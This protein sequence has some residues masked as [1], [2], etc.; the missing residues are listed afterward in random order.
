M[1]TEYILNG[2]QADHNMAD[3]DICVLFPTIDASEIRQFRLSK[4]MTQEQ[5]ANFYGI[6][7]RTLRRWE[8]THDGAP[9][10]YTVAFRK[11]LG[12][13]MGSKPN[14]QIETSI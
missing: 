7:V 9:K 5:F 4:N 12:D 3:G 1:K 10:K 11:I 2:S 6:H 14:R 13:W 8:G